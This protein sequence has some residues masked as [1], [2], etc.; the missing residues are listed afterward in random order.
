LHKQEESTSEPICYI[1]GSCCENTFR[2][3]FKDRIICGTCLD[4]LK[5]LLRVESTLNQELLA[6]RREI[7]NLKENEEKQESIIQ[8][9]KGKFNKFKLRIRRGGF[10]K[11]LQELIKPVEKKLQT[12]KKRVE[13]KNKELETKTREILSLEKKIQE[14]NVKMEEL[15]SRFNY[16]PKIFW[17]NPEIGPRAFVLKRISDLLEK[18]ARRRGVGHNSLVKSIETMLSVLYREIIDGEFS[19]GQKIE[20]FSIV[21][22]GHNRRE[23]DIVVKEGDKSVKIIEVEKKLPFDPFLRET[24]IK[25]LRE[26]IRVFSMEVTVYNVVV[27]TLDE[28][29]KINEICKEEGVKYVSLSSIRDKEKKKQLKLLS[30]LKEQIGL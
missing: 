25:S 12:A 24:R 6:A 16:I 21:G 10:E 1:C 22:Q 27:I 30:K 23:A 5:D 13:I 29:P 17:K 4:E 3:K 9:Q 19:E 18:G 8:E 7:T 20:L 11:E 28:D 15:E 26:E 14:Q 2:F